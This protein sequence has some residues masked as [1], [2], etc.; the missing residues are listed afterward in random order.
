MVITS[1]D[2]QKLLQNVSKKWQAAYFAT[3]I[4]PWA[5]IFS[6]GIA[7]ACCVFICVLW[8]WQSFEKKQWGWLNDP[9]IKAGII[10]WLWMIVIVSPFAVM[11]KESISMAAPWIRYILLYA[12]LRYWVLCSRE[13]LFLLGKILAAMLVLVMVDTLWQYITGVSIT[14][15]IRDKS[16]RLTGPINNVKVGI[17]IAKLLFPTSGIFLFFSILHKKNIAIFASVLLILSSIMVIMLSGERTAFFSTVIAIS[18]L[19]A[20]LA[21]VEPTFRKILLFGIIILICGVSFMLATQ[22]WVQVRANDFYYIISNFFESNY[23]QLFKA[24]YFIGGEHWIT[25]AGPKG[26]RELCPDLITRHKVFYCNIHPHNPYLEWFSEAGAI[27]LMLF[28]TMISCLIYICLKDFIKRRS[29]YRIL[30]AFAFACIIGNFFPFMPTQSQFS[31]WPA[32][33]LWYSVSVA[34]ASLNIKDDKGIRQP[35]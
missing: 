3:I 22:P 14:G 24:G 5:L 30:P 7:D 17:F 15:H 33:L 19:T 2:W 6:R 16:G 1:I 28:I 27:G 4:L 32:I 8:L 23:G 20:C 29:I 10:A 25:G 12:A 26:F 35:S 13:S 34:I 9:F 11:P 31:N 18:A 21:V